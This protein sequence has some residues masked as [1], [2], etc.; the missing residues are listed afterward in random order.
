[1]TYLDSLDRPR[2]AHLDVVGML[3]FMS[4]INQPSLA[5]PFHSVLASI[6]VFMALSTEFRSIDSSTT[7]FSDSVLPVLSLPYWSFQIY[8][9]L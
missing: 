1:M 5:T 6:S 4:D 8:V 3:W 9:S 2:R 7:L